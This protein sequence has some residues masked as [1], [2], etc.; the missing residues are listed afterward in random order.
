MKIAPHFALWCLSACAVFAQP[1]S[2]EANVTPAAE[3]LRIV[4]ERASIEASFKADE[5]ACQ[6]RFFVSHCLA[7][8]RLGR[9]EAL[10]KLRRQELVLDESDRKQKA[11]QQ[12]LKIDKKAADQR[13]Q[14]ARAQSQTA[15]L[16]SATR[17]EPVELGAAAPSQGAASAKAGTGQATQARQQRKADQADARQVR[18][19]AN[20]EAAQARQAKAAQ[21]KA[22]HERRLQESSAT[23]GKA[24]AAAP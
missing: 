23:T 14:E 6:R 10:A 11:A 1:V 2:D 7:G 16:E 22:E 18:A 12:L 24:L 15:P 19:A 9:N 8:I 13:Q 17:N 21:R 20:V 4:G 5:A 3:R